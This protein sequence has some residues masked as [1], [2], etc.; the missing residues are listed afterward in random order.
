[1]AAVLRMMMTADASPLAAPQVMT[2]RV[3]QLHKLDISARTFREASPES[4]SAAATT[5]GFS[6]VLRR[7]GKD[8]EADELQAKARAIRDAAETRAARLKAEAER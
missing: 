2:G 6:S 7:A 5:E 8:D 1:M 4:L 3:L